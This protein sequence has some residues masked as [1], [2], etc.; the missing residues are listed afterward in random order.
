MADRKTDPENTNPAKRQKVS[1][2]DMD[3]K[4]NPYL[5]HMYEGSNTNGYSNGNSSNGG[6][7][8][9]SSLKR[10]SSTAALA[11]QAEDGPNNAFNNKPLSKN[12]FNIL[13]VRRNLPVHQQRFVLFQAFP[14]SRLD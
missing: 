2:V 12:Y 9:L 8:I 13:K 7:S 3:P 5:A 14:K 1:Q 6:S 4:S 11:N 10:H